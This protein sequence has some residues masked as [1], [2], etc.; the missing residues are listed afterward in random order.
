MAKRNFLDLYQKS[1]YTVKTTS[2]WE[3]LR[4]E[5]CYYKIVQE[6]NYS[7]LNGKMQ[8]NLEFMMM[9]EHFVEGVNPV[10]DI[11][12]IDDQFIAYRTKRVTGCSI[13][14]LTSLWKY[15]L[16]NWIPFFQSVCTILENAS[17]KNYRFPD[18]F[19]NGNILYNLEK[20]HCTFIDNDGM[21]IGNNFV[22]NYDIVSKIFMLN[23]ANKN[24]LLAKYFTDFKTGVTSNYTA[25]SFYHWF[26]DYFFGL[27]LIDYILNPKGETIFLE[28]LK[29]IQ[30]PM[31]SDFAAHLADFFNLY[32]TNYLYPN[33]FLY[34]ANHFHIQENGSQR[35]L[36]PR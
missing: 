11:Y 20:E 24:P 9:P 23:S 19:T 26:L 12:Y 30:F 7:A 35:V 17:L 6:Q 4:D 14:Q 34:L 16:P 10:L 15:N 33:D 31:D 22:G 1:L 32:T 18:L 36:L 25:L 28:H 5:H 13:N 3:I 27:S 2:S 8:E 29:Q 21:Q